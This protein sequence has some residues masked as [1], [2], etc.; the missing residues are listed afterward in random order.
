[1]IVTDLLAVH[2]LYPLRLYCLVPVRVS[3]WGG[4]QL[5]VCVIQDKVITKFETRFNEAKAEA[6]ALAPQVAEER[7]RADKAEA[8]MA[9]LLEQRAKTRRAQERQAAEAANL[10]ASLRADI[11]AA[12]VRVVQS[13]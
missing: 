1:M 13:S 9:E 7:C 8:R 11:S 6:Q 3:V 4:C 2:A 12:R 5:V 10:Q